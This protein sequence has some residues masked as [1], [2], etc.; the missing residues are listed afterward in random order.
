MQESC[1]NYQLWNHRRKCALAMGPG[2]ARR[3]LEVAAE[4]L[5]ED[6]KNYHAWT[7]RQAIVK[8]CGLKLCGWL[9]EDSSI[10]HKYYALEVPIWN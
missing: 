5:A 6:S 2:A 1:K 9:S 7:H 8:V 4:A 3:E 10:F